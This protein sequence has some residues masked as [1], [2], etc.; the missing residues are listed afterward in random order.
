MLK[1]V[2]G[3]VVVIARRRGCNGSGGEVEEEER[4]IRK[5]R[6]WFWGWWEGVGKNG[7]DFV[8]A[9]SI[10]LR[11]WGPLDFPRVCKSARGDDLRLKARR[12]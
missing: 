4:G 12:L 6:F 10:S 11:L 8:N 1:T 2:D 3:I 7:G 5:K 9:V